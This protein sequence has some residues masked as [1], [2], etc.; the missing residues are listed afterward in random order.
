MKYSDAKRR[1]QMLRKQIEGVRAEMRVVLSEVEP[2]FVADHVFESAEGQ[3]RLSALFADKKELIVIHNM[4]SECAYCTLWADGYNGL[5]PHVASRASFVIASPDSPSQQ[6]QFAASRGW[7]FPMVS[8]TNAAFAYKMGYASAD[9]RCRPGLS[10]FRLNAQRIE[11][12]IDANSCPHDDYCAIW[13][14]FD[15]LPGGAEPWRPRL[16]YAE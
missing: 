4:G 1:L 3:T 11:R 15:L 5:Y 14:L 7:L 10:V 6:R 9:G 16:S 13:H 8:D 2:D 12:I